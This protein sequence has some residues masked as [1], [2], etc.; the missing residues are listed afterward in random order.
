MV[1]L[2]LNLSLIEASKKE[3]S[4]A[5]SPYSFKMQPINVS[6]V[7]RHQLSRDGG[8]VDKSQSNRGAWVVTLLSRKSCI[9]TNDYSFWPSGKHFIQQF[10]N[11]STKIT[12]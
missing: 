7:G 10:S 5:S 8:Q 3:S 2:A 12:S 11:L 6:V 9:L 1:T 4:L